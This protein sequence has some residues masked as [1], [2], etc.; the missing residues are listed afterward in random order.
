MHQESVVDNRSDLLE[1]TPPIILGKG[2]S[3]LQRMIGQ[4]IDRAGDVD[5]GANPTMYLY[6]QYIDPDLHPDEYTRPG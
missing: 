1:T 5:I 2:F 6:N 4:A 3:S